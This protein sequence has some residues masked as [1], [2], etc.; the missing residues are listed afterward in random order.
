M[1]LN[2]KCELLNSG[3]MDLIHQN[4]LRIL[5][6][7]GLKVENQKILSRL[8]DFGGKVDQ[9]RHIVTFSPAL[10]ESF[11][12]DTIEDIPGDDDSLQT[13]SGGYS[14]NYMDINGNLEPL[15]IKTIIG[16]YTLI[17]KLP[18]IDR[19][20]SYIGTPHDVP[21]QLHPLYDALL[22]WK[23]AKPFSSAKYSVIINPKLNPYFF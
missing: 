16:I 22:C 21:L 19:P 14:L 17:S 2:V 5:E 20:H 13:T 7:L 6:E 10:I 9:K 11:I 1:K 18:Y 3:E 15:T 12:N 23:Y 8:G 4:V